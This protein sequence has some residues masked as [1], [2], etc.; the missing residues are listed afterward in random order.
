MVVRG[1][2]GVKSDSGYDSYSTSGAFLVIL[3][4]VWRCAWIQTPQTWVRPKPMSLGESHSDPHPHNKL[5]TLP[6]EKGHGIRIVGKWIQNRSTS[7]SS[8]S[9]S[10]MAGG[11]WMTDSSVDLFSTHSPTMM[12][13]IVFECNLQKIV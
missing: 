3:L 5:G 9:P 7:E 11:V 2:G 1:G 12:Y 4:A 13:G 10:P 8:R 6:S